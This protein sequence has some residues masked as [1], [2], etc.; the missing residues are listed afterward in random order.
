MSCCVLPTFLKGMVMG[1]DST[2]LKVVRIGNTSLYKKATGSID[3]SDNYNNKMDLPTDMLFD[4]RYEVGY[5]RKN[6]R[7]HKWFVNNVQDGIDNCAEY[8]V[9][10]EDHLLPLKEI[11]TSILKMKD[12][13]E[14]VEEIED[15]IEEELPGNVHID[16]YFY[17]DLRKMVDIVNNASEDDEYYY[18][19]SW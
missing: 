16:E 3:I 9:L 17:E 8:L 4:I 11:C 10:Y 12:N 5:F 14:D 18:S 13:D 19:S 7:I 6:D 2:L 15:L 1:L